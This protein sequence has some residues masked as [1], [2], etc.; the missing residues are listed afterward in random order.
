MSVRT[1]GRQ[2]NFRSSDSRFKC[3][4]SANGPITASHASEA[5]TPLGG[6]PFPRQQF[7]SP[8]GTIRRSWNYE[9][10]LPREFG[11]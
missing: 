7:A 11:V 10:T 9:H 5:E 1:L 3:V 2:R 8:F 6:D 4:H